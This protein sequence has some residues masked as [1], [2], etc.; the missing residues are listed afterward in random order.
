[1]T[2]V[3]NPYQAQGELRIRIRELCALMED[4]MWVAYGA[5]KSNEDEAALSEAKALVKRSQHMAAGS[6]GPVVQ[7]WNVRER[8]STGL[9]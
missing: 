3:P 8:D 5:V 6:P 7:S 2:D 1:M 4:V 9:H